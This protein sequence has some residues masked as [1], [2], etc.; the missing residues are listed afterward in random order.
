MV[1]RTCLVLAVGAVLF[2]GVQGKSLAGQL[3]TPLLATYFRL[4][5]QPASLCLR[6]DSSAHGH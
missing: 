2:L 6:N 1:S 3:A 5:K 4:G